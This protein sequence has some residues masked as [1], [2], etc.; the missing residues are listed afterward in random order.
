MLRELTVLKEFN[1]LNKAS[2]N[3]I[4]LS[5]KEFNEIKRMKEYI[6]LLK[7]EKNVKVEIFMTF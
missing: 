3:P 5:K 7:K 2:K 4:D 6:N 1:I